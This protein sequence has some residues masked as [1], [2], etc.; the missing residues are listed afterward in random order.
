MRAAKRQSDGCFK[1]VVAGASGTSKT[2]F[3]KCHMNGG[4]E[5]DENLAAVGAEV[6]RLDFYTNRGLKR[7]NVSNTVAHEKFG[8][9]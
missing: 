6:H 4:F 2:I 9:L 8:G 7:F 5:K 3:V 1:L